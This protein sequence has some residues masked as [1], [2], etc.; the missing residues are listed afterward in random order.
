MRTE[1][2]I[3]GGTVHDW[4]FLASLPRGQVYV[5]VGF[6]FSQSLFLS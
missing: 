1:S 3:Y 6:F 4:R 5:S 2:A